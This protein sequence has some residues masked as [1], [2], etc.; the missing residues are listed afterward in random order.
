M[1][2]FNQDPLGLDVKGRAREQRLRQSL[3]GLIPVG[4]PLPDPN[5]EGFFQSMDDQNVAGIQ[6]G[7]SA[8]GSQQLR[9]FGTDDIV[10]RKGFSQS[11]LAGLRA[12]STAPLK[13]R[14]AVDSESPELKTA[15]YKATGNI[16]PKFRG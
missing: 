8:P 14:R 12:A 9:G 6:A 13:K 15:R 2:I 16:T 1:D 7:E 10:N 3:Q 11:P 5:W 4:G